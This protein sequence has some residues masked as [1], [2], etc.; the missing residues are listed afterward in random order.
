MS[1][2]WPTHVHAWLKHGTRACTYYVITSAMLRGWHTKHGNSQMLSMH[3]IRVSI[4]KH[5]DPFIF[6]M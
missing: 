6:L 2:T 5:L 3:V 1:T 4:D